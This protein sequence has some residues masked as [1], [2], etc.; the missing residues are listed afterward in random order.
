LMASLTD[1]AP[2]VS[3]RVS[4]SSDFIEAVPAIRI[5]TRKAYLSNGLPEG[6]A[7]FFA[8]NAGGDPVAMLSWIQHDRTTFELRDFVSVLDGAGAVLLDDV[9]DRAVATSGREARVW[10]YCRKDIRRYYESVGLTYESEYSESWNV[11]YV[12]RSPVGVSIG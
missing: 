10:A 5:L 11:M 6:D 3:V 7:T 2:T 4:D 9:I 8:T 12:N 1:E